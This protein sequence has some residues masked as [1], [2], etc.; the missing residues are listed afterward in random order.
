MIV[1]IKLNPNISIL[2]SSQ[3]LLTGIYDSTMQTT[4]KGNLTSLLP[5]RGGPNYG[6]NQDPALNVLAPVHEKGVWLFL[7][8]QM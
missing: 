4:G 8:S 5:I 1:Q 6:P 7:K 2:K 3:I